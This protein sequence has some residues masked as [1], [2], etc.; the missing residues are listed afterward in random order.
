[1]KAKIKGIKIEGTAT[2]FAQLLR[3]LDEYSK[4]DDHT[5]D[6]YRYSNLSDDIPMRALFKQ[7]C[8]N[9][10]HYKKAAN[11]FSSLIHGQKLHKNT[12]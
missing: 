10:Q 9:S 6:A 4:R 5:V 11:P 3:E 7:I 8:P 12:L 2:E 1:M